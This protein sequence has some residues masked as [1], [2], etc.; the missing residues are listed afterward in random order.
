MLKIPKYMFSLDLFL[1]L[2][3]HICNRLFNTSTSVSGRHFK[4]K[5]SKL[6]CC[7]IVSLC[8]LADDN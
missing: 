5:I 7:S 1:E 2:Q 3:T 4:N 8:H 6:D